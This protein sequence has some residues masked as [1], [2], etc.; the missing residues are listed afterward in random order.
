M[1]KLNLETSELIEGLINKDRMAYDYL[2]DNYSSKLYG[3]A[4]HITQ[5]R[6]IAE[7]V[8]Q[9]TFIKVYKHID[10]YDETRG[11]F[12]T[13]MLNICRNGAIDKIRYG[14]ESRKIQYD[15]LL[16][17]IATNENPEVERANAELWEVLNKLENE[18]KEIL[19][20]SYYYGYAHGEISEKLGIPLG[21]VKSK[22]RIALRELRKIY[23]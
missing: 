5:K 13:W 1:K 4:L 9:E 11:T 21:T 22:I 7:D 19:K 6:D 8:L 12:F 15:S 10:K 20:L 23:P 17:D 3:I 2:Y 16:V 18:H 14:K